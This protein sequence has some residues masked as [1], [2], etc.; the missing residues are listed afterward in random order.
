[1]KIGWDPWRVPWVWW[2]VSLGEAAKAERDFKRLNLN[3][4]SFMLPYPNLK[5]YTKMCNK[6]LEVTG[7]ALPRIQDL[8]R[9][10]GLVAALRQGG[11]TQAIR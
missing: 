3:Q 4:I 8:S 10:A 7:V 2:N 1:M 9:A 6:S 5:L 11:L